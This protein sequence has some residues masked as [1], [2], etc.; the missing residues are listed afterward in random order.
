MKLTTNETLEALAATP[1]VE[2][3]PAF[4]TL[5][6]SLSNRYPADY[7]LGE[8]ITGTSCGFNVLPNLLLPDRVAHAFPAVL[9][10]NKVEGDAYVELM[11][12][13]KA[14]G[15]FAVMTNSFTW[16]HQ[17]YFVFVLQKMCTAEGLSVYMN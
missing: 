6:L 4:D 13:G 2:T 11:K 10:L 3:A 9:S 7:T 17:S 12:K 5:P 14:K 1:V 16:D 8:Y 15:D